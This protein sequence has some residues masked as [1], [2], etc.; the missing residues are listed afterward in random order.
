M[1]KTALSADCVT[2][3]RSGLS[4]RIAKSNI[5]LSCN[6]SRKQGQSEFVR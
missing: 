2:I 4:G 6:T 1:I 3:N 5:A